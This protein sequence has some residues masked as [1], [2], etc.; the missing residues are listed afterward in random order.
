MRHGDFSDLLDY[1]RP[2][3]VF[4]RA[5]GDRMDKKMVDVKHLPCYMMT[6]TE[7]YF[8][9]NVAMLVLFSAVVRRT[10][11]DWTGPPMVSTSSL[12]MRWTTPD[13]RL[14]SSSVETS[15][16]GRRTRT[17]SDIERLS[18]SSYV[19]PRWG[20]FAV[21]G[22]SLGHHESCV[23]MCARV[24]VS[25]PCPVSFWFAAHTMP[26]VHNTGCLLSI[27]DVVSK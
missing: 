27:V 24:W 21:G 12:H 19:F 20:L 7:W 5:I 1:Y 8:W 22:W 9:L 23:Y 17:L 10:C 3:L 26:S 11:C 6:I 25:C 14:R 13:Q 2:F 18:L 15:R 16:G 4:R